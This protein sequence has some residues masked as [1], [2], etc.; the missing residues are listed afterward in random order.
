FLVRGALLPAGREDQTLAACVGSGK[1]PFTILTRSA[2]SP[3]RLD[4]I[5]EE[6]LEPFTASTLIEALDAAKGPPPT[7]SPPPIAAA[8]MPAEIAPPTPPPTRTFDADETPPIDPIGPDG[9]R[10]LKW[11]RRCTEDERNPKNLQETALRALT[12]LTGSREGRLYAP[13]A[14]SGLRLLCAMGVPSS[15]AESDRLRAYAA[16]AATDG[17]PRVIMG[18]PKSGA[19]GVMTSHLV[20]P[21]V[22]PGAVKAVAVLSDRAGPTPYGMSDIEAAVHL[23]RQL[24]ENFTNAEQRTDLEQKATIDY[25]TGLFTRY[26]FD[27]NLPKAFNN[28]QRQGVPLSLM[29]IDVD[30]L[31]KWNDEVSYEAGSAV[32]ARIGEILATSFRMGDMACRYGGDEMVVI[33]PKAARGPDGTSVLAEKIRATIAAQRISVAV[34]GRD[35]VVAPTVSIG[36]ATYPRDATTPEGLFAAAD[37]AVKQAKKIK[38]SVCYADALRP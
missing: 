24:G 32:L 8:P 37:A 31:K 36:Y 11:I 21:L 34:N 28:A 10:L 4:G 22:D 1:R 33:L 29:F 23:G 20:V 13:V 19:S 15:E 17:T 6:I 38:N 18:V 9:V 16:E 30:N 3:L 26:N 14:G 27:L 2:S 35:V 25:A 5:D 7:T 12:D